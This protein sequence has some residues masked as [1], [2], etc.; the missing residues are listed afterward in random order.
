MSHALDPAESMAS[1]CS[2]ALR[3]AK[4]SDPA[5]TPCLAHAAHTAAHNVVQ[6]VL[7]HHPE[8]HSNLGPTVPA[9][10]ETAIFSVSFASLAQEL[11]D[12]WAPSNVIV[13]FRRQWR[14]F[15]GLPDCTP[16]FTDF[17]EAL[18]KPNFGAAAAFFVDNHATD[19]QLIGLVEIWISHRRG[20]PVMSEPG[21]DFGSNAPFGP[22]LICLFTAPPL[23]ASRNNSGSGSSSDDLQGISY[24]L[25]RP[26]TRAPHPRPHPLTPRHLRPSLPMPARPR[27]T[28]AR[29]CR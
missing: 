11:E 17:Y 16:G 18:E 7:T 13:D 23:E 3:N 21:H 10:L 4:H 14:R 5:Q 12:A 24:P 8:F 28:R 26:Y 1:E 29:P 20:R 15:H 9:A 25:T 2:C 6:G 19:L 22:L 27:D